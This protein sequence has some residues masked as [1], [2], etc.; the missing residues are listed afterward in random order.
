V[1]KKQLYSYG[2]IAPAFLIVFILSIYASFVLGRMT[3]YRWIL[4]QTSTEAQWVGLGNFKWLLAGGDRTFWHSTKITLIL[5]FSTTTL[6][7]ILGFTIGYL[8]YRWVKNK[9]VQ[10]IIIGLFIIPFVVMPSMV[11]LIWRLYFAPTGIINFFL[12]SVVGTRINFY[13]YKWALPA[14]IMVNIWEWTPFFIIILLAGFQALPRECLEA[15]RV[16]GASEWQTLRY[17]IFP[18]LSSLIIIACVLRMMEALRLFEVI[19]AMYGGGPFDATETLPLHIYRMSFLTRTLGK[20]ATVA[21][22]LNIISL[23]MSVGFL[24]ILVSKRR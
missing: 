7:L 1:K 18:M 12:Q 9:T 17:I 13:S 24:S 2:L 19:Y 16:D 20:G 3:A 11:G 6:E 8:I 10:G 5:V 22:V 4:G 15:V 21:V 23:G 14:V